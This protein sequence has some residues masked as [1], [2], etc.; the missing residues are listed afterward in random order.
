MALAGKVL[1]I[2]T[3]V[4]MPSD[5]PAVKI[6]STKANGA[7]VVLY[8]RETDDRNKIANDIALETG[9]TFVHPFDDAD[10]MAG[11]GTIALE[12]VEQLA[13]CQPD[14]ILIC[15]SGKCNAF[16]HV[17]AFLLFIFCICLPAPMLT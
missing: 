6:A 14:Q 7:H 13:G 11:Q 4:V 2:T 12:I 1:G 10:V 5:A 8:N 3:T 15:C 17:A 9:A 16:L